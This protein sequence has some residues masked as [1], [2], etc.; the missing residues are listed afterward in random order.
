[1]LEIATGE[2]I[3]EHS[4]LEPL[5]E[6][7]DWA[8]PN[9]F[10]FQPVLVDSTLWVAPVLCAEEPPPSAL[11]LR[12]LDSQENNVFLATTEA[13]LH[14][15]TTMILSL[16]VSHRDELRGTMLD[17]GCGSGVL[18]IGALALSE[19]DQ[20]TAHATDVVEAAL[21]CARRNARL[22]GLPDERLR[23]HMPWE[24]PSGDAW[25]AEPLVAD[26]AVANMLPGPLSSVAAEIIS[27]VRPGGLL[28]LS[29]FR[30]VD[31]PAVRDAFEPYFELPAEPS[32]EAADGWIALA[33]RRTEAPITTAALSDSAVE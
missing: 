8:A 3:V 26:V 7:Q 15:S 20:L 31:L 30:P 2:Q 10:A 19:P 1:M 12:L 28:L 24:V 17:Y 6:P 9:P 22:N 29:G 13:A 11:P 14:A 33:C 32:R 27:R 16:L 23:L 18:A 25:E 21:D 5:F 4:D